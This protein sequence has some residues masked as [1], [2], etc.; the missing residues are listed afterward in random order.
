VWSLTSAS[1]PAFEVKMENVSLMQAESGYEVTI[2]C[3]SD[4]QQAAFWQRH[5]DAAKGKVTPTSGT[6]LAV[7]EDWPGGAGNFLG[8]LY[9][10]RKACEKLKKECGRDLFSELEAGASVAIF[11]TAG[12]GTR[13]APLPGAENNNKPGV[14]LPVCGAISILEGVIRQTGAYAASRASRLSVF[15]GDQIFVPSVSAKYTPE[16]HV[17]IVCAL[18]PMPSAEEWASRGLEKY[19]LIAARADGSVAAM[20]EKVSHAEALAQLAGLEGVEFVGTSLGSFSLS[21]P[22]LKALSNH[23]A[24]EL[25]AKAGKMDSDPHVWMPMTLSREAYAALMVKKGLLDEAAAGAHHDRI[26]RLLRSFNLSAGGLRG[27]FGGVAVGLDLSWWDYGLLKLYTK[28]SLLLTEDSDDARLARAFFGILER[29]RIDSASDL[30]ACKADGASVIS[31]TCVTCGE[32]SSSVVLGVTAQEVKAEGAVLVNT[33]AKRILAS[34]GAVAYN[35]VDTSEEGLVLGP[36]EVRAGVFTT[37]PKHPYFEMRS[38]TAEVDGGKAFRER[39]CGNTMSFQ[40]VYDL[41]CG[42]DVTACAEA[43]ARARTEFRAGLS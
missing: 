29:G 8:T 37:D 22:L 35:V 30:G 41:N 40:E 18:G 36:Q 4:S 34:K 20:L 27:L 5:L 25:E 21:A 28:N 2:V 7:D 11:H 17:D 16:H 26:A 39:V 43:A 32:V 23:F 3:T 31:D 24:Q 1:P 14:R 19:G 6:V 42:M 10:W 33:C 15:W 38:N 9:A 13:M 12:K